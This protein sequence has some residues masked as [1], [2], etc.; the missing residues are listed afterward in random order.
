MINYYVQMGAF[1]VRGRQ[2]WIGVY[3]FVG[4]SGRGGGGG[5]IGNA[6]TKNDVHKMTEILTKI[7]RMD[8]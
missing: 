4:D 5:S 7:P 8:G 2:Q 3:A 6:K 1:I